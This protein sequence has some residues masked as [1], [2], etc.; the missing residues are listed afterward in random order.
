[1]G[2]FSCPLHCL[3]E[4]AA[5]VCE[6]V[7]NALQFLALCTKSRAALTAENLFLRKQLAYYK[8]RKISPRRFNNASRYLLVLLSGWFDWKEAL[9]V[10]TP[11]T[12]IGW[13]RAGFLL[14]WRWQC[15][16]GRPRIPAELRAL[17]RRM[18]RDNVGWG[19]ER[20]A[21]ELLLKLGI[22]I[23]PR[24]VRKYMPKRPPG[25]PRGD[26]RWLTFVHNHA[27][28]IVAC[29]F[30]TVVTANFK[31]LYVFVVIEVGRRTLIHINVTA[32]PTAAWTLQQLREAIPS[33]HNYKYLL[34]DRD[35]IFS[36][37]LMCPSRN[38]GYAF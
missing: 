37:V 24:T 14:F 22:Q 9:V 27:N 18:A 33:D 23:S 17:I 4:F 30:L 21:N 26:Q 19:E 25:R 12:L 38:W 1:M 15:R 3:I 13:H 35:L 7:K 5:L 2:L 29:D 32:H 36:T 31:C 34:H 8:E 10:V 28:A 16:R 6:L 20:I 11:K